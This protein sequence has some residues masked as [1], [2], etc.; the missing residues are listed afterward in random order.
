VKLR[1]AALAVLAFWIVTPIA[2]AECFRSCPD[3]TASPD[4]CSQPDGQPG[5]VLKT[6]HDCSTHAA[7]PV[8]ATASVRSDLHTSVAPDSSAAPRSGLTVLTMP[9]SV[10]FRG[11]S[12][13]AGFLIPLRQ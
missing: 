5:A 4:H 9:D 1:L 3:E 6:W 7:D 11:V 8:P 2:A 12:P 10:A 13:P